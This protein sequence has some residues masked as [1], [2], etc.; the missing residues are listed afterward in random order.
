MGLLQKWFGK[1][2]VPEVTPPLEKVTTPDKKNDQ[3][4][5]VPTF[6]PVE[7]KDQEIPTLIATSL[8]ANDRPES[9]FVIKKI[10][11]HNPEA[12]LVALVASS[13]ASQDRPESRFVVK[14]IY[15]K[16][17]QTEDDHVTKI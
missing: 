17:N 3:W 13:V 1:K 12:Q 2:S 8:A 15:K 7:K 5:L 14:S 16:I 4:E 9:Q 11:E 6:I 10:Q